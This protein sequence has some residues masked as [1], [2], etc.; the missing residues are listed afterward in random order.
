MNP[1]IVLGPPGTGKTTTLLNE[2][3]TEIARGVPPDRIGYVSFTKRAALEA[4]TRAAAK[5][6][7][8]WTDFPH[9][10]TLH[11]LCFRQ[12]GYNSSDVFEGRRTKEFADWIGMP[13]FG[14]WSEDGLTAGFE[15]GDRILFMENLARVNMIPLRQQYDKNDD[16]Q[17]W[18]DV[19][20]FGEGLAVWK[21]SKGLVDY[22]DMLAE[23]VESGP[24]VRLEVLF[25]D[26]AQDLS[27]LQWQ[28][29]RKLA[30]KARRVVIAGDD[31]QAIYRW[32]GADVDQFVN[33]PGD[34]RVLGQSWRCP[35]TVQEL[36]TEVLQAI[37]NRRP[38]TW[39]P[40]SSVGVME[41]ASILDNVELKGNDILIL[42][43]NQYI[44][45]EQVRPE[46]RSRGIIYEQNG[47]SSVKP[48]YLDALVAWE[49]LRAGKRVTVPEARVVYQWMSSGEGVKRGFKELPGFHDDEEV[50]LGDLQ[51]RGGLLR[52][53]VWHEALDRLPRDDMSYLL[54][55]RRNGEKLR[56][57]PRVKISTIH[58]AKGGEAEHVVVLT[59]MAK[60]TH[61]EMERS[62][63]DEARVWYVAVT[64]TREKLTLVSPQTRQFYPL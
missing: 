1:E 43:R 18:H 59:E 54:A 42:A 33:L 62:P 52:T 44:L 27:A 9:F 57:R 64:R 45:N 8:P 39:K 61:W 7:L 34:V 26:E 35:E 37:R 30:T 50:S 60:R 56:G 51:E 38:K 63:E 24:P 6:F 41:R 13:I 36:S 17:T 46:L 58:G 19:Q 14:R 28:V 11:S 40:R 16:D 4:I 25:V 32:A 12:M 3:E 53:D 5:F 10:R 22:T 20:R 48:A 47:H 29:V 23:F 15:K 31:D 21:K 49:D 55:A 2:V